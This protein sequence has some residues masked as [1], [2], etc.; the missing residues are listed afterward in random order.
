M[1]IVDCVGIFN[2][3]PGCRHKPKVATIV[4]WLSGD[5]TICRVLPRRMEEESHFSHYLV[6]VV[7]R[8]PFLEARVLRSQAVDGIYSYDIP[9]FG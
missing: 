4:L 7:V 1:S 8:T 3:T 2:W 6:H 9:L 5:V